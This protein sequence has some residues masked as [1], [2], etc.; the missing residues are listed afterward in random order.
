MKKIY[1]EQITK[2]T[3][4]LTEDGKI[5]ER[6]KDAEEYELNLGKKKI[7]AAQGPFLNSSYSLGEMYFPKTEEELNFVIR[8]LSFSKWDDISHITYDNLTPNNWI[9][10]VTDFD[11]DNGNT[12]TI[13]SLKELVSYLQDDLKQIQEFTNKYGS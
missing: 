5:F 11:S 3:E 2:S 1:T 4:Y 6:A 9:Y 8:L 12:V 10:A 13:C 7:K